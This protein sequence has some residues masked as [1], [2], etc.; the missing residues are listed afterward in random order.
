MKNKIYKR[1]FAL[2]LSTTIAIAASAQQKLSLDDAVTIAKS[3]NPMLKASALDISRSEQ[4]R[5][6]AQS[7][8]LPNVTASGVVNHYFNQT[9][10][11]GF[12]EATTEDKIPYGRFGGEDQL[13]AVIAATQPILNFQA[14]P[15]IQRAKLKEH[16]S[17]LTYKAQQLETVA[18]VKQTY[19][20]ALVLHE[21]IKVQEESIDRN[22]LALQDARSLFAQGKGLRVDTLRAFTSVKNLEPLLLKLQFAEQTAELQLKAL[23]GIDSLTDIQLS[24]SLYLREASVIPSE[25]EV[26]AEA[27]SNNPTYQ[28]LTL[29]QEISERQEKIASGGR[30]P[31][32]SAIAAYQ[33]NSQTR[34]FNYNN[35]YFPTSSFIGLQV[36]VPLFTGLSNQAKVR[37]AAIETSQWKLRSTNAFEQLRA[38]A[39]QLVANNRESLDRLQTTASV[40]ETARL[41]YSIV[42]Y[43]YKKGVSSRLELTDAELDLANAQTNYLEAVY[44]YL[45]ARIALLKLMGREE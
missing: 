34:D 20:Q 1:A 16:E 5:K 42:E 41:S 29:Q 32:V 45:S 38:T 17:S 27:R 26:Y 21:R 25:N 40:S 30:L 3:E 36:A 23:L 19:L 11:F 6:I 35:A 15:A 7:L 24:D 39:H 8:L 9:P 33:V 28:V 18:L 37:D 31:T 43:R 14:Y 10:F 2:V 4:Q 22:K 12:G 44:D 13:A